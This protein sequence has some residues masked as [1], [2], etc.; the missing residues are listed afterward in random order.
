MTT[1]RLL[2]QLAIKTETLEARERLGRELFDI[3]TVAKRIKEC[4]TDGFGRLRIRQPKPVR[5]TNTRAADRLA[6]WLIQSGFQYR[7]HETTKRMGPDELAS[8]AELIIEWEE[9]QAR[10]VIFEALRDVAAVVDRD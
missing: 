10:D 1:F 2:D 9:G 5:L 7:W 6:K 8:Y 3:A 4:S